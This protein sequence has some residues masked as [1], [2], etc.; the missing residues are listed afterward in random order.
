M[1]FYIKG[2]RKTGIGTKGTKD[3]VLGIT[4]YKT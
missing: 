1:Q 2:R 4:S 3:G